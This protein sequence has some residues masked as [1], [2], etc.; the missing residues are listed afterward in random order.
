MLCE[1]CISP[2]RE[3]FSHVPWEI[4]DMQHT[5]SGDYLSLYKTFL[6]LLLHFI[7]LTDNQDV[8]KNL[9]QF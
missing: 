8:M 7:T 5:L 9:I 6:I 2:L 1:I 4:R 3:S